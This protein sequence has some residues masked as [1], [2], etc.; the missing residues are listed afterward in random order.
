MINIDITSLTIEVMHVDVSYAAPQAH[1]IVNVA[2]HQ[3]YPL[4][5][6]L[7]NHMGSSNSIMSKMYT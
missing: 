4:G 7:F 6:D 5:M 2:F 1:K 3:E